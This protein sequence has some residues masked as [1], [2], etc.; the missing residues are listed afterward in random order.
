MTEAEKSNEERPAN[1]E[2]E[3]EL[4]VIDL[5]IVLAKHKLLIIG[6][7]IV[8][9]LIAAGFSLTL[10]FVYTANTKIFLPPQGQSGTSALVAQLGGLA[11]LA[12]GIGAIRNPNDLYIGILKSQTVADNLI[13]RFGLM[14]AYQAK[15]PSRVRQRLATATTI[16]AGKDNIITIS[17]DDEDPKFAAA[18]ANAYVDE[19]SKLTNVLA[20]TDASRRRLFFERQFEQA[21]DNLTKAEVSAR[22]ALESGGLVQVEGQGRAI[23]EMSARLRG[24][25]TVKEV[26][27]GS[28]RAFATDRNPDLRKAQEELA[29]LKRELARVEGGRGNKADDGKSDMNGRGIASLRLLRNVKYHETIYELLAKQYELAKIDEAKESAVIQIIDKAIEPDFRSKPKRA[30]IVVLSALVALVI[31]IL[32]AFVWE[33]ISKAS[34]DPNQT[35][36]LRELKAY[37]G[38]KRRRAIGQ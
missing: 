26:E 4:S 30:V 5:L 37:L 2:S 12:G 36:R 17:V 29:T 1:Q 24:E 7:P 6:L 14:Q 8:V 15:Y 35:N 22:E 18:L 28:M 21:R 10:P 31:S 27:I 9:A 25:I 16:S 19:F 38:W 34:A 11:G 23:V 32:A 20:L 3:D 33:G 13:Q